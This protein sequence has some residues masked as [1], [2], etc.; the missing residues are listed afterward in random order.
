M[1]LSKERLNL[2]ALFLPKPLLL[3]LCILLHRS[4][5]I[6]GIEP[7]LE[8]G[9]RFILNFVYFSAKLCQNIRSDLGIL[10]GFTLSGY[11]LSPLSLLW[12]FSFSNLYLFL[13]YLSYS[14]SIFLILFTSIS[15]S[16]VVKSHT[17]RAS[18]PKY[19]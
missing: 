19:S 13:I 1:Q 3:K 15:S 4:N 2:K 5:K 17:I 18:T 7:V 11:S 12:L 6:N 10:G 9:L 16:C 8:I 14:I